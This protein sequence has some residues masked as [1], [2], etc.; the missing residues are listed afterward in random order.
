MEDVNKAIETGKTVIIGCRCTVTYSG[1]AE[2]FLEEGDRIVIIKPDKTLLIHQPSGSNPVNYMKEKASHKF[3][4]K[5]GG[6][7]LNSESEDKKEFIEIAMT[8]IHSCQILELKDGKKLMLAGSEKDMADMIYK[9]PKLISATFRP[10]SREEQT[11]YG[12]IDV[13]G[14]DKGNLV[15][16]ECK[17][18]NADFNAVDQLLRYVKKVKRMRGIKNVVGMIA[19]PKISKNALQM[20]ADNG[21]QFKKIIPPKYHE[22]FNKNQQTLSGF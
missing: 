12:F 21:C 7:A 4:R 9:E 15:I 19:A 11:E 22:R 3:V 5:R 18:Y 16:I 13:F 6:Y 17:R 20:L 10:V 2:S 8:K 1:R 14:Y